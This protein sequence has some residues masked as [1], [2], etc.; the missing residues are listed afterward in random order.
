MVSVY[1]TLTIYVKGLFWGTDYF[2]IPLVMACV[3]WTVKNEL[4]ECILTYYLGTYIIL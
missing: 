1:D 4:I 2:I 3:L